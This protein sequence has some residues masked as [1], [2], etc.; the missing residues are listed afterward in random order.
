MKTPLDM[1]HCIAA[2]RLVP[3]HPDPL[4]PGE[5]TASEDS[6]C[7]TPAAHITHGDTP[8]TSGR[9]SLSHGERAGVRGNQV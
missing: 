1:L 2:A 6:Y 9:F 3:P 7:S 4:P 8:T 5:G